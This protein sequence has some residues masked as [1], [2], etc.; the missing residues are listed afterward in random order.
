MMLEVY[1]EEILPL[2]QGE[3]RASPRGRGSLTRPL[4][5]AAFLCLF[6]SLPLLAANATVAQ[7]GTGDY[8]TVQDAINAAPQTLTADNRWVILVKPGTYREMV[9][10]QREKHFVTLVGEDPLRTVIT[11]NLN[12]NIL[13][14]D[15]K[16]IGTFRTPSVVIDADDFTAEN[17]TFENSAGPVGQAVAVRID[18]D[19]VIFR[20]CR[21]M[22]WQDTVLV[23]RGRHYFEDSLITGH[24][25]FIFGAATAFFERCRIHVW[26]SGYITAAS[27]PSDQ[28][29][30]LVFNRNTISGEPGDVKTY[31]GRPWRDF[32]QVTFLNTEMSG[33]VRPAGWNN[34]NNPDREKTSRY[35]EFGS[36]GPGASPTER[37][38]WA[39]P[40]TAKDATA[41]TVAAVLGGNDHWDPRK[42]AAHPSA[43]KVLESPLP[44]APG[45]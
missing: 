32:A 33:V 30:G 27:T 12:A 45:Q 7:D 39:K 40:I 42:V 22:G 31:L 11:Y 18:G 19:R 41:I 37:A 28:R 10:V 9:Y 13:G 2:K 17:L 23:N 29:Y 15:G 20:N 34:W 6:S 8:R 43:I 36:S 21:F 16:P 5:I 4:C 26:R 3:S 35:S 1:K 14:L 38:A 44:A 25:D 24:V